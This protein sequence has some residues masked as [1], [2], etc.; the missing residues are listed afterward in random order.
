MRRMY[1]VAGWQHCRNAAC[2]IIVATLHAAHVRHLTLETIRPMWSTSTFESA[3]STA[4][5]GGPHRQHST[6]RAVQRR[7]Q[8]EPSHGRCVAGVRCMPGVR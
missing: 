8:L 7:N 5:T 6:E 3:H 1:S 2:T 4:S